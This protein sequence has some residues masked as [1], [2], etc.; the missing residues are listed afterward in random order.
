MSQRFIEDETMETIGTEEEIERRE[1][2]WE[3]EV[4]EDEEEEDPYSML[5][6]EQCIQRGL[7][8]DDWNRKIHNV[9]ERS[10][11]LTP[12]RISPAPGGAGQSR[13][14][15]HQ[16]SSISSIPVIHDIRQQ[17]MSI[18]LPSSMSISAS[19]SYPHRTHHPSSY[20]TPSPPMSSI[21]PNGGN[22]EEE[23]EETNSRYGF[24]DWT[25]SRLS[26]Q[27]SILSTSS[28]SSSSANSSPSISPAP[29][30]KR[31]PWKNGDVFEWRAHNCYYRVQHYIEASFLVYDRATKLHDLARCTSNHVSTCVQVK[32]DPDHPRQFQKVYPLEQEQ[33]T[34]AGLVVFLFPR[35]QGKEC[36]PLY[37]TI[38]D[39]KTLESKLFDSIV[40]KRNRMKHLIEV[41]NQGRIGDVR[42]LLTCP[43]WYH[44]RKDQYITFSY[45][46]QQRMLQTANQREVDKL[47][48]TLRDHPIVQHHFTETKKK[49]IQ[50]QSIKVMNALMSIH[51]SS[52]VL[53]QRL[54]QLL[55]RLQIIS[56][57]TPEQM[58]Q[59]SE[60]YPDES[61]LFLLLSFV[62]KEANIALFQQLQRWNQPTA[63]TTTTTTTAKKPGRKKH[64]PPPPSHTLEVDEEKEA[65][66]GVVDEIL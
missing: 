42:F 15:H 40:E 9:H 2:G 21:T 51:G 32:P 53:Q 44:M 56:E 58:A 12:R 25:D 60:S 19:S 5:D 23:E 48:D 33:E 6:V 46:A 65:V 10:R 61:D 14:Y 64:V 30:D 59:Y 22:D 3:V 43:E 47:K 63:T 39:Q 52:H 11:S 1:A 62:T 55:S 34:G 13:G 20:A 36:P 41:N 27:S 50:D 28:S 29:T 26:R 54:N 38:D 49:L 35:Y 8:L 45:N 7:D 37:V 57:A 4:I 18:I 24:P 31:R 17:P 66:V 16:K